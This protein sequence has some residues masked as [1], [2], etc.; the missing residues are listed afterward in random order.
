MNETEKLLDKN[1]ADATKLRAARQL[2]VFF[3]CSLFAVVGII[4]VVPRPT[5]PESLPLPTIDLEQMKTRET[6]ERARALRAVDN[7]LSNRV[8]TI[9]EEVRRIGLKTARSIPVPPAQ[10]K[11]L[12]VD[13]NALLE[14]DRVDELLDLRAL[15]TEL[16]LQAVRDF[17]SSG[18]P[19]PDL[20]ELGGQFALAAQSS[21]LGDE[22]R[23]LL[24][25]N[26]LRVLFRIH[27]GR[28]TGLL[29]HPSFA[30]NLEELRRYYSVHLRFPHKAQEND[31]HSALLTQLKV[32]RA[33]GEVDPN[34]PTNLATGMLQ[35]K[36]GLAIPAEKSLR[37]Y[38]DSAPDGP[39]SQI[40][41]NCLRLAARQ[42][43]AMRP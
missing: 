19:Q 41:Q 2:R 4:I 32:V 23:L 15:Q 26:Q 22:H 34:Y 20:E 35:L 6:T 14:D 28:T 30:P 10:L 18:K 27:W 42:A 40:A 21:W 39:W 9:G 13:V 36:L 25:N 43:R 37:S 12:E 16:F 7:A 31:F 38:L 24:D 3:A 1:G 29:A 33:L 11:T 17:E 8:R 5:F